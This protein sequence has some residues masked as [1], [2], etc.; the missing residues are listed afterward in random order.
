MSFG[1]RKMPV[2]GRHDLTIWLT[3]L[4]IS[5]VDSPLGVSRQKNPRWVPNWVSKIFN[6][7]L[8]FNYSLWAVWGPYVEG[9]G[10]SDFLIFFRERNL[11]T[12]MC[13]GK[14]SS[15]SREIWESFS[16]QLV[17]WPRRMRGHL[18]SGPFA[19]FDAHATSQDSSCQ[20]AVKYVTWDG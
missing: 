7:R 11:Y 18:G 19:L 14:R 13:C 12:K 5:T 20:R 16:P 1:L 3:T 8:I 15:V 17:L 4:I 10:M 2:Y 6:N 9:L